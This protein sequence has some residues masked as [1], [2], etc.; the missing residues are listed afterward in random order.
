MNLLSTTACLVLLLQPAS[1]PNMKQVGVVT[2]KQEV[3]TIPAEMPALEPVLVSCNDFIQ[4]YDWDKRVAYAVMM[5]E[6]G[7][8]VDNRGDGHLTFMQSNV[9]YGDSWG[10]FQ[11][12]YL[13]GRPAP[14]QLVNA[15][16]NVEYAYKM[17]QS[18]GWYPWSAWKN[19]SYLKYL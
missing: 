7:G 13:P 14:E 1:T 10:C 6:S 11:I 3:I 12:R 15:R 5:A 17:W 16:F 4:Q 18:Q 2:Q 8:R 19:G 9:R